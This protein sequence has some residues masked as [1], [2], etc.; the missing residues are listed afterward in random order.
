MTLIFQLIVPEL[1]IFYIKKKKLFK[2]VK[3]IKNYLFDYL[4]S[5]FKKII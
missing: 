5:T 1:A 4:I 2:I 3:I